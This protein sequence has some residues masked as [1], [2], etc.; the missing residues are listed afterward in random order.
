MLVPLILVP[1]GGLSAP[2]VLFLILGGLAAPG[3]VG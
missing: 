3:A 1:E 2:G